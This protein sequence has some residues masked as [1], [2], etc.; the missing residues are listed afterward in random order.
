MTDPCTLTA[1]RM[2][3]ALDSG[4][5]TSAELVEAHLARIARL[6]GSLKAFT[7]VFAETARAD[8]RRLDDERRGGMVRGPLHGLPVTVKECFDIEGL[9]TTAGITSRRTH[10]A[11]RD[12]AMITLLRESGAVLLGRTNLSQTM[13]FSE[14]R[15]PVY[16]QTANPWSLAHSPGG[17]SGG[18]A[19]AVASG[20]SPLGLGTDIGGSIRSPATV[21]G[22]CG[23]KPGLDRLPSLGQFSVLKGQEAVRSVPGPI[24]RTTEDLWLFLS[25]LDPARMSSLDP[26]VP[27]LPWIDPTSVEVSKLRIGYYS[28]DGVLAP[29]TA[30]ERAVETAAEALRTLGCAVTL[31]TP[32]DVPSLFDDYLGAMSADGGE[33]LHEALKG[34][35][36][37]PSL[38]PL[39]ALA[40]VPDMG[41]QFLA[42]IA[43]TFGER[44]TQRLLDAV[45]AR[46]VGAYWK[47][48]DRLRGYRSRLL[49]AMDSAG[50]DIVLCPAFA[51]PALPHGMSKNFTAASTPAIVWN[52]VQFPAGVIPATTVRASETTRALKRDLVER[53]AASVDSQ[54]EGLPVGVQLAAR[55]WH[56]HRVLAAMAA[57]ERTLREHPDFPCTPVSPV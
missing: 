24:A 50:V 41:R 29:S 16:G 51:T 28:H 17:S 27:P 49:A 10:R 2:R 45:G 25:A 4:E 39:M 52:A 8:A 55:P 35:R 53:H 5:L 34:D 32:P 26:R 21:T 42:G 14:S 54:S 37:D 3:A 15:N 31:F 12:A 7:R 18:E 13:L 46:S 20:M 36:V 47:L 9:A 44:R 48:T 38:K 40:L 22:V 43:K 6:D 1:S 11:T 23:F 33:T 30:V 19:S 56:D 57:L